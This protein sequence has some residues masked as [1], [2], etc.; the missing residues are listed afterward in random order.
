MVM[1]RDVQARGLTIA[2]HDACQSAEENADALYQS[3]LALMQEGDLSRDV[4]EFQNVFK[5]DGFHKEARQALADLRLQQGETRLAYG[6]YLRLIEQ[7]PDTPDVRL[8]LAQLA[9]D[10][11]N[12][13]EVERHGRAAIE[14]MPDDPAV[15]SI[16]ISLDYREGVIE[17]DPEIR[18]A[19]AEIAHAQLA[20]DPMNDV[21]RRI[22]IDDLLRSDTPFDAMDEINKALE[23]FP[24]SLSYHTLRLRLLTQVQNMAAIGTQLQRMVELFPEEDE[25][26]QSLISWYLAQGDTA[27]AEDFLRKLAGDDTAEPE[28]HIT[29]VQLIQAT[30]GPQAAQAELDRL[31]AANEGTPNGDIYR[32]LSAV[33]TFESGAPD[34]A[35]ATIEAIVSDAEPTEQTQDIR[36][37]LARLYLATDNQVGA[38]ATVETILT[39]DPS[40]VDALKLRAARAIAADR[41][42]D[43]RLDLRTALTQQP[44]AAHNLTLV[45]PAHQR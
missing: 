9:L 26:A 45:A 4:V 32:A 17:D 2:T 25:L 20:A 27:G 22:V 13:D 29:V 39:D 5:H 31:A 34:T 10:V 1:S 36:N 41:A 40:N 16:A 28:G 43:A 33:I 6:Q 3:G 24:E 18:A 15:Q 38:R 8:K 21:A 19:A 30:R 44:L 35:I 14:M 11:G 42:G 12:W 7:Y 37:I 23:Q